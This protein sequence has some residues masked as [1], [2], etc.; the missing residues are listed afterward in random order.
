MRKCLEG[1]VVYLKYGVVS[2]YNP[3][4]K[5]KSNTYITEWYIQLTS[6]ACQKG[7]KIKK[8]FNEL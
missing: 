2:L 7:H 5:V 3:I 4:M 8:Y 6:V 1:Y